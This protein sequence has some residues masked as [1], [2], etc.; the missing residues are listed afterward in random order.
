MQEL[1][2]REILYLLLAKIKWI[3]L[4][5]VAGAV[6]LGVYASVFVPEL[7]TSSAMMYISNISEDVE[8]NA[9]TSSNLT[10]AERLVT[11][12]KTA[13]TAKWALDSAAGKMGGRMTAGE[14]GGAVSFAAVKDTSFLRVSVTHTDPKLAQEACDV[15]LVVAV[16]AFTA[17]GE[18]GKATVFQTATAAGQTSP[19][20]KRSAAIGAV[21]GAIVAVA[22][23]LLC[24]MFDNTVRDK[25]NLQRRLNVPVLGE[26]P[27]FELAA[28]G[29]KKHV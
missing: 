18:T 8:A 11:T 1:D 27:S 9:A 14:L 4:G 10:A 26:I 24:K 29:G 25:E 12:V 21:V 22:I 19:N 3:I 13:T 7:Y 16:E 5:F 28:K 2:L 15:M 17:T 6:L 23:I 20:V